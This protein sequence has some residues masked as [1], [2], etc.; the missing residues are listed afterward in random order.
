[1]QVF[2]KLD[3]DAHSEIQLAILHQVNVYHLHL[4]VG[5][6]HLYNDEVHGLS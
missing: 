5:G 3:F 2:V 4:C 1:M 6:C